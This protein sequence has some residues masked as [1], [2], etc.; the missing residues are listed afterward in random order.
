MMLDKFKELKDCLPEPKLTWDM[1]LRLFYSLCAWLVIGTIVGMSDDHTPIGVLRRSLDWLEVPSAFTHGM[2]DWCAGHSVLLEWFGIGV[3]I[4]S[5]CLS[6]G[7]DESDER[8]T[9]REIPPFCLGFLLCLQSFGDKPSTSWSRICLFLVVAWIIYT[10]F[11]AFKKIF[12][13][14]TSDSWFVLIT[15]WPAAIGCTIVYPLVMVQQLL[16]G[17]SN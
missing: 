3:I 14:N 5:V 12:I 6:Y 16:F 8:V 4:V 17:N 2:E 10:L 7:V 9:G 11:F 1:L 15:T 13:S